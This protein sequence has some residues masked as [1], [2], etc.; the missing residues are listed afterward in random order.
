M[1]VTV[2]PK[3]QYRVDSVSNLLATTRRIVRDTHVQVF[4][5]RIRASRLNGLV[6]IKR[7]DA[8]ATDFEYTPKLK[9]KIVMGET[10]P[11][12][13]RSTPTPVNRASGEPMWGKAERHET[14]F[15]LCITDC[16]ASNV[17]DKIRE[18]IEDASDVLIGHLW[19]K[20][21]LGNPAR[22]QFGLLNHELIQVVESPPNGTGGSS[23]WRDKTNSQIAAEIRTYVKYMSR[24]RIMLA[25]TTYVEA[26]ATGDNDVGDRGCKLRSNCIKQLLVD[27]T[28]LP[29]TADFSFEMMEDLNNVSM[30]AGSNVAM[31]YDADAIV[32]TSSGPIIIDAFAQSA[33]MVEQIME[34][35]T[36]ALEIEYTDSVFL[37]TGV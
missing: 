7:I 6:N 9:R 36:G 24:P 10:N 15:E 27:Q 33:K 19:S 22:L 37:L 20:F 29:I 23:K 17:E 25:E 4:N 12:S 35:N 18:G 8:D 32:L 1:T 3:I 2:K 34:I 14:S 31:I 16:N 11:A 30:Y 28:D 26:L 13:C 21:W 5:A